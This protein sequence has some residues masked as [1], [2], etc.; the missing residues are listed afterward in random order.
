MKQVST[1]RKPPLNKRVIGLVNKIVKEYD[2][3]KVEQNVKLKIPIGAK[4]TTC[5]V[6]YPFPLD[7]MVFQKKFI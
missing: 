1:K 6:L 3:I 2:I 5:F 4:N 7:V